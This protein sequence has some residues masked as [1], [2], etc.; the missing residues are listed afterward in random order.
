MTPQQ[1]EHLQRVKDKFTQ[2][3]DKKYRSGQK[4]HG[5][6]LWEKKGI[7]GMIKEEIED[8]WVY[9]VTLEEQLEESGISLGTKEDK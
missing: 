1:E 3:I 8:L 5:G 2:A 4:E 9:V 7:I 6:N